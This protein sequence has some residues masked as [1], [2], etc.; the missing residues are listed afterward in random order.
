VCIIT[1]EYL[2]RDTKS[3]GESIQFTGAMKHTNK[4]QCL[5]LI[6]RTAVM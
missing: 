1:V 2:S 3:A 4:Y 5:L 6:Y